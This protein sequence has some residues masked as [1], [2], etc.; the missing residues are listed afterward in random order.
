MKA[1]AAVCS[2]GLAQGHLR[3][4]QTV[5]VNNNKGTC[6]GRAAGGAHMPHGTEAVETSRTQ[7]WGASCNST[8][9]LLA[10]HV[11]SYSAYTANNP[12]PQCRAVLCN[13]VADTHQSLPT[14]AVCM[15]AR[16]NR[17]ALA[18]VCALGVCTR[19]PSNTM[20]VPRV[21]ATGMLVECCPDNITSAPHLPRPP[22]HCAGAGKGCC[23]NYNTR[24]RGVLSDNN[25]AER[26]RCGRNA[27]AQ[28]QRSTAGA[29]HAREGGLCTQCACAGARSA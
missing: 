16:Q 3:S 9:Y 7:L 15:L 23:K 24:W 10:H 6:M 5:T 21:C 17:H 1:Q 22:L 19:L 8:D 18:L 26:G 27:H 11:H 12:H 28:V 20:S 2:W 14:P 13:H 4:Q 25:T 29:G